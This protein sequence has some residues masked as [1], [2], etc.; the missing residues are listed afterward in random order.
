[1]GSA[2][3]SGTYNVDTF[4]QD[5]NMSLSLTEGNLTGGIGAMMW[6]TNLGAIQMSFDPPIDK[7]ET[8]VFDMGMTYDW[9]RSVIP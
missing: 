5:M 7:D 4:T 6:R 3:S 2:Y 8:K 9:A 1:M